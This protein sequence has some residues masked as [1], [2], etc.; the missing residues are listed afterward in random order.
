MGLADR[1]IYYLT[2]YLVRTRKYKARMKLA[3]KKFI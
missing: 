2:G 1:F 3:I